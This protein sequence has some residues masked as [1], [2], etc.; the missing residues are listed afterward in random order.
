MLWTTFEYDG[1]GSYAH[2]HYCHSIHLQGSKRDPHETGK[3]C[4]NS[5]SSS[6]EMKKNSGHYEM[7]MSIFRI[8]YLYCLDSIDLKPFNCI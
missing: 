8:K 7:K 5:V 6:K 1:N 4:P 2:R 3:A